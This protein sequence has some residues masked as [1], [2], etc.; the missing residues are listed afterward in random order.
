MIIAFSPLGLALSLAVLAPTALLAAFPPRTP[1]TKA[2]VPGSLRILESTGQ[3]LCMTVPALLAPGL[4]TWW[5]GA[6]GAAA[7]GA[8]YALWGRY[9]A[10]GRQAWS[11]YRPLGRIPVPMAVFPV[12]VFL[13]GAAWLSS[14]GIAVAAVVLAA[15]HIPASFVIARSLR[16]GDRA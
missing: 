7:L 14:P 15:G 4:I 9:L 1:L 5:W 10:Q 13:A 6:V 11:L 16:P 3:A 8:Y 2:N 12:L